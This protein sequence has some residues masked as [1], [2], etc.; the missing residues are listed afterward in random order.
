L[1]GEAGYL[2]ETLGVFVRKQLFVAL[3]GSRNRDIRIGLIDA[4][5]HRSLGGLEWSRVTRG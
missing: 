3:W 5:V 2:P 1:L 4:A